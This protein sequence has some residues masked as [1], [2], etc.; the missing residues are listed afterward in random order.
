M[1]STFPCQPDAPAR[2]R[3]LIWLAALA[4]LVLVGLVVGYGV[5]IRLLE[6]PAWKSSGLRLGAEWLLPTNDAYFE[7]TAADGRALEPGTWF[8]HLLGSLHNLTGLPLG[9]IAFWMPLVL[10]PLALVPAMILLLAWRLPAAAL[11]AGVF[12]MSSMGYLARTRLGFYDSDIV[13]VFMPMLLASLLASWLGRRPEGDSDDLPT[14]R[15][16]FVA[17]GLAAAAALAGW[18][19]VQLYPS[20]KFPA[21]AI[22]GASLPVLLWKNRRQPFVPLVAWDLMTLALF[23]PLGA[24]AGFGAALGLLY[25][26][27]GRYV[28]SGVP[29]SLLFVSLGAALALG[30]WLFAPAVAGY[31]VNYGVIE[32]PFGTEDVVT[33]GIHTPNAYAMVNEVYRPAWQN[34]WGFHSLEPRVF[35][36]AL[37][38]AVL[39][40]LYRPALLPFVPLA[41]LSLALPLLGARFSLYSPFVAVLAAAGVGCVEGAGQRWSGQRRWLRLARHAL[42]LALVMGAS[43]W[44]VQRTERV[45]AEA[46]KPGTPLSPVLTAQVAQLD[47]KLAPGAVIW[48]WWDHG[49]NYQYYARRHTVADSHANS[50]DNIYLPGLVMTLDDPVQSSRLMRYAASHQRAKVRETDTPAHVSYE[51]TAMASLRTLGH[52]AAQ[53]FIDSMKQAE[54]VAVAGAPTQ[55]LAVSW[56]GLAVMYNMAAI[57]KWDLRQGGSPKYRL[58]LLDNVQSATVSGNTVGFGQHPPQNLDGL[59]IWE[60]DG[61]V[62]K[63]QLAAGNDLYAIWN[64]T[65]HQVYLLHRDMFNATYLRLLMWS[66]GEPPVP[67]FELT[68]D[69]GQLLRVFKSVAVPVQ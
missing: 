35:Y 27:E 65:R 39:G 48:C 49:F 10:A 32:P 18:L 52:K 9:T 24:A 15:D 38:L 45:F 50:F 58:I 20:G 17:L 59:A 62:R 44:L 26:D 4:A 69:A 5:H 46:A 53:A 1:N 37:G 12:G 41:L 6:W 30:A 13:N 25:R 31:L 40:L 43:V 61:T 57:G 63:V 36:A 34:L 14:R 54:P 28:A 3:A 60:K 19:W 2:Q 22:M 42:V 66:P 47:S 33:F 11:A 23:C 55:Y 68:H 29:R 16:C 67:G 64:K 7:L 56:D 8:T 51:S 21:L